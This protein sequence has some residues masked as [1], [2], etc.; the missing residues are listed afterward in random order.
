MVAAE[1]EAAEAA[2]RALVKKLHILQ[3]RVANEAADLIEEQAAEI[4]RLVSK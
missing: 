2:R 3:T 4:D 1:A